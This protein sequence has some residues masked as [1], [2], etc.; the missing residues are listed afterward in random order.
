MLCTNCQSR[1]ANFHYKQVINGK[2]TELNLCTECARELGY[3]NQGEG[4]FDLSSFF[5]DF[6]SMPSFAPS[7]TKVM[8]CPECATTFDE[9]KRTGF[10]GCERCYDEFKDAIEATLEQIQPSTTHKGRLG[11]EAGAKIQ[12]TNELDR[13]KEQLKRAILDEKYED[14][15]VLRDKIKKIEEEKDNG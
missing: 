14:A 10:V 9:F 3:L 8:A 12:K 6:L 5:G 15:A 4:M 7:V 11:G 1:E 2:H 13:L